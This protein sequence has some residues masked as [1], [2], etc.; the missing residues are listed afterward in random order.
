MTTIPK[1]ILCIDNENWT[2]H[3]INKE[4]WLSSKGRVWRSCHVRK[5]GQHIKLYGGNYLSPATSTGVHTDYLVVSV[6]N[7]QHL[8]HR[9]ICEAFNGFQPDVNFVVHH[10]DGNG[11]NNRIENLM[12]LE[13]GENTAEGLHRH[14]QLGSGHHQAKLVENDI[15]EICARITLGQKDSD[16]AKLFGVTRQQIRNIR[17]GKSWSHLTAVQKLP[18]SV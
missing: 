9:L 13:T 14:G 1:P 15:E 18:P 6:N 2:Q 3:P 17:L 12:W 4:L 11:L 16:I 7:K 8:M 5:F 10:I